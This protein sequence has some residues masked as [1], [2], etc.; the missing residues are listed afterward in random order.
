MQGILQDHKVIINKQKPKRMISIIGIV[1]SME[2][3]EL[4]VFS[5]TC[6]YRSIAIQKTNIL[7]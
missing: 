2:G 7:I 4:G 6:R 3:K 5:M 1:D